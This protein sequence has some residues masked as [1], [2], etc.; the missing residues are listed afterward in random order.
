MGNPETLFNDVIQIGIVVSDVNKA[1]EGYRDLLHLKKW[2]INQVDTATGKGGNFHKN[3][4]PIQ[5]KVRIAWANLGNVELELIEPQDQHSLYAEFLRER[6]PGIHHV[7]LGTSDYATCLEHMDSQKIAAIGGG[8]LQGTRFQMFDAQ[9][10]LGFIC[11]IAE[12]E[13]LVPDQTLDS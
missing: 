7:M 13:P 11:E 5:A 4:K 2:N 9:E 8:E 1:I 10:L 3:G 12:G 6:G